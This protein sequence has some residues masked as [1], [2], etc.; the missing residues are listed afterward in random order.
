LLDGGRFG[1]LAWNEA[2][3][4]PLFSVPSA[5]DVIGM[6]MFKTSFCSLA[7]LIVLAIFSTGVVADDAQTELPVYQRYRQ[8]DGSGAAPSPQGDYRQQPYQGYS[9]GGYYPAFYYPQWYAGS[10]YQRPYPYHF[11]FY[12][13]RYAAGSAAAPSSPEGRPARSDCPCAEPQAAY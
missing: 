5:L 6:A 4:S 10:W 8:N 9:Y 12:K 1:C 11:D 2:Q 13:W 7:M 3:W